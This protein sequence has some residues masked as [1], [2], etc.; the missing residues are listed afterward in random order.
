MLTPDEAKLARLAEFDLAAVERAHGRYMTAPDGPEAS[1]AARDYQRMAR[2][3][4]QSIALKHKIAQD[5]AKLER[6]VA[7]RARI[8]EIMH[9]GGEDRPPPKRLFPKDI[10]AANARAGEIRTGMQRLLWSEGFEKSDYDCE[11]ELEGHFFRCLEDFLA[12]DRLNDDFTTRDLDEQIAEYAH[13]FGLNPDNAARWRDL[14]D[15][16]P[17]D[18]EAFLADDSDDGETPKW[19]KSDSS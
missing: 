9:P 16:D 3:L 8:K 4:R 12:E 17:D 13:A 11:Q 7:H 1:A 2:S 14:P 10:P 6:E 18:V 15:P 5:A 19:R